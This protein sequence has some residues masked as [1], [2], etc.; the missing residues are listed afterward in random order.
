MW[1]QSK[2]EP[3]DPNPNPNRIFF[4]KNQRNVARFTNECESKQV[5]TISQRFQ[6]KNMRKRTVQTYQDENRRFTS[7]QRLNLLSYDKSVPRLMLRTIWYM[8]ESFLGGFGKKLELGFPKR[9]RRG[10]E[11]KK[12][13]RFWKMNGNGFETLIY[14]RLGRVDPNP[15]HSL[16]TLS[17]LIQILMDLDQSN[18]PGALVWSGS[19]RSVG[20]GQGSVGFKLL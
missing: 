18:A 19:I 14:T 20:L 3:F 7:F 4:K 10:E 11:E 17:R 5:L 9:E 15:T 6:P 13:K 16:L 12:E 8:F 2:F 1:I